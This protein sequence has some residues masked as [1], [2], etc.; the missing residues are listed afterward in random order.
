M[1]TESA[2]EEKMYPHIAIIRLYNSRGKVR[3]PFRIAGYFEIGVYLEDSGTLTVD[4]KSYPLH[5]GDVRFIRP[6]MKI[7]SSQ[8]FSCYSCYFSFGSQNTDYDPH[9][10]GAIPPLLHYGPQAV[11]EIRNIM[12]LFYSTEPGSKLKMN[13]L[14]LKMLSDVYTLSV[15]K[16]AIPAAVRLCIDYLEENYGEHITLETLGKLSGYVPLHI[17]RL[18]RESTGQTPHEYLCSYRLLQAKKLL[19]TTYDSINDIALACGFHSA[20]H[21]QKLFQKR[22]GITPNR[23]RKTT[24]PLELW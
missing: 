11:E 12:E 8:D 16:T 17:L 18:F 23:F 19:C 15:G 2:L 1:E 4:G 24:A 6:G 3:P 13:A 7:S 20:S 14:L 22:F 9:I 21:F 5:A 10:V